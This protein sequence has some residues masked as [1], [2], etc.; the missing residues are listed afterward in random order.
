MPGKTRIRLMFALIALVS[1]TFLPSPRPALAAT[2]DICAPLTCFMD[3]R[4]AGYEGGLCLT[5]GCF[6][7]RA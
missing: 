2:E 6:C 3:C 4:D 5:G 1:A 7:W